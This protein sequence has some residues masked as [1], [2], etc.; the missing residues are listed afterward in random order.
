GITAV[1]F[2]SVAAAAGITRAGIIYHFPSRDDLIA[3]IHQRLADR[4]ERQ[5]VI[6]AATSAYDTAY[7][8]TMIVLAVMLASGAAL[9][10]RL[11]RAYGRGSE[12][13]E[14]AENH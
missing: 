11:L 2:D 14:Y 10:N 12:A 5:F 9:T 6:A 3:A 1:T 13:M 8:V 4:W 7:L